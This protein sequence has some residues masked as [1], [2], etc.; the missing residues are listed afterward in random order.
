[1]IRD[2][3]LTTKKKKSI[4]LLNYWFGIIVQTSSQNNDDKL[5]YIKL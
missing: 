1:M 3:G 4:D 2:N 5:Y